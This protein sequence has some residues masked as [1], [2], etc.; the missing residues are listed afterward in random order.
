[1]VDAYS[2]E[3]DFENSMNL[4]KLNHIKFRVHSL[5]HSSTHH[6]TITQSHNKFNID[7]GG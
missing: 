6:S 2:T 4:V 5:I 1:M 3:N 7:N